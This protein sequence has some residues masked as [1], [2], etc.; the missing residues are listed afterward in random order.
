[1]RE[2]G[3]LF[4]DHFFNLL[5]FNSK[6]CFVYQWG[7]GGGRQTSWVDCR[8]V[9]CNR[10]RGTWVLTGA[11]V[12]AVMPCTSL[13]VPSVLE[14]VHVCEDKSREKKL[15]PTDANKPVLSKIKELT[16]LT[17]VADKWSA[18]MSHP[19]LAFIQESD[20]RPRRPD[21]KAAAENRQGLI[22]YR[23]NPVCLS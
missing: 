7:L 5:S 8:V 22:Y 3:N 12:S 6:L 21:H 11:Q 18:C 16:F 19:C 9:G 15:T 14:Q 23:Y 4:F 2:G 17:H 10:Q 20:S 1:M 13:F